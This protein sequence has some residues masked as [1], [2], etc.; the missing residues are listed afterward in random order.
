[1]RVFS[2]N[3]GFFPLSASAFAGLS[4]AGPISALSLGEKSDRTA[5]ES[6]LREPSRLINNP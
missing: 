5:P 4:D 1:M 3:V 6:G 2:D